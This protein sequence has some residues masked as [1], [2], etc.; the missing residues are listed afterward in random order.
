MKLIRWAPRG[1]NHPVM[2]PV[3]DDTQDLMNWF[4]DWP[5]SMSVS[6]RA[7]MPRVDMEETEHEIVVTA[8][9]PGMDPENIQVEVQDG[10][11]TLSAEQSEKT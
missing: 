6:S 4:F 3:T 11:F 1:H 7:A 5:R 9:V 10:I 8:D 2:T